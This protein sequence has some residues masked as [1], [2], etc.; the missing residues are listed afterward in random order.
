MQLIFRDALVY[1]NGTVEKQTMFFDGSSISPISAIDA[2]C[3][4][5]EAAVIDNIAVFPG[6]CDVH[7]HF[8]EPG[9]SYKET[10]KGGSEAAVAGG[11]TAVMTM[12]KTERNSLWHCPQ[13]RSSTAGILSAR[14]S[15][16]VATESPILPKIIKPNNPWPS[17]NSSRTPWPP[18]PAL[19][20]SC[21]FPV[22]EVKTFS[23]A[24]SPFW[25]KPRP[26]QNLTT[27]P[28]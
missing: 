2:S 24:G 28:M 21:L 23:T 22:H 1:T 26:W 6:F 11:Y 4:S 10:I 15:V 18:V 12:P 3:V 17:R 27:I 7:V 16:R 19:Q 20:P 5:A 9:F 8:R 13:D 25:K 14:F